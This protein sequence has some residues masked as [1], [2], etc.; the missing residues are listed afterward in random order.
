MELKGREKQIV[1]ERIRKIEELRK[2]KIN[3]YAHKIKEI[4][5]KVFT[6][7]IQK[8]YSKLKEEEFSKIKRI[9]QED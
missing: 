9:L 7:E 3:P 5:K 8:N 1:D 6:E 2:E 4:N